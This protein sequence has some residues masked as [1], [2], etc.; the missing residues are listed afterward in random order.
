VTLQSLLLRLLP[1]PEPGRIFADGERRTLARIAEVLLPGGA[2]DDADGAVSPEEVAENVEGFLVRGRSKRAWRVRGLLYLVEWSPLIRGQRRLSR[3]TLRQRRRL[4]EDRYV[5][6]HG[7]WGICAK[8][9][10]LVIM[11]AYGDARA[12]AAASYV[13]VSKRR[14]FARAERNGGTVVAQ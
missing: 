4:V 14:R 12:H 1:L 2:L 9:R 13:P 3:M 7:I 5:D 11:G 6:G 8:I 10:F